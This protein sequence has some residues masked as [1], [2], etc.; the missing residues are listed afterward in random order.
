MS[1][2]TTW[3]VLAAFWI[4]LSGY[5]DIIHLLFG[6]ASVTLVSAMSH[7]HL[8]GRGTGDGLGRVIRTMFYIPWLLWQVALAN[9]DVFLRVIGVRP[10]DPRMIRIKVDLESDY[11]LTLLAN[12]ITLTPGTV[13]VDV[14]D[15]GTFLVHAIA[16]AAADGVL[17][18]V[19][20]GHVREVESGIRTTTEMPIVADEG[21]AG[22]GDV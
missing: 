21:P 9:V 2:L 18:R 3:I 19:M 11:G 7:K 16:P 14:G 15:D 6:A 17:S 20:E 1:F 8:M 22:E 13:T 4:G 10:I 5:F 12:S